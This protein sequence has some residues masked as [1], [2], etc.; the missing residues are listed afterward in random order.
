M[1]QFTVNIFL[2]MCKS[3][4]SIFQLENVNLMWEM[5]LKG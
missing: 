1:V 2:Q 4:I 5:I 3:V